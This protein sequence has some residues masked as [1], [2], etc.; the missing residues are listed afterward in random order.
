MNNR[1]TRSLKNASRTIQRGERALQPRARFQVESLERRQ[2]RS[3]VTYHGGPLMQNPVIVPIFYGSA[4]TAPAQQNE[5]EMIH[6]FLGYITSGTSGLMKFLNGMYDVSP[7]TPGYKGT[8]YTIGSGSVW[9]GNSAEPTGNDVVNIPVTGPIIDSKYTGIIKRQIAIGHVP[10]PTVNTIYVLLS[11]P[12]VNVFDSTNKKGAPTGQ[13]IA[14][15]FGFADSSLAMGNAYYATV[16]VPGNPGQ[17]LPGKVGGIVLNG[18]QSVTE[19][20]THEVMETITDP[21]F[22]GS[23]W[24]DKAY[25]LDGEIADMGLEPTAYE[26]KH[27]IYQKNWL[28]LLHNYVVPQLWSDATQSPVSL[29]GAKPAAT[30]RATTLS[31]TAGPKLKPLSGTVTGQSPLAFKWSSIQNANWYEF[32]LEDVTASTTV[33]ET[34]AKTSISYSVRPGD[35]YKWMVRAFSNDGVMGHWSAASRFVVSA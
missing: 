15:H 4:W 14:Y 21:N 16:A 26:Q 5:I 3:G 20:L 34:T 33:T 11:P 12:G 10:T 17:N 1:P 30:T 2:L 25:P 29:P 13:E 23:G 31:T 7:S 19:M 8:S 6:T 28:T 22:D 32:E 9:S 27:T 24:D 35:T 18:F